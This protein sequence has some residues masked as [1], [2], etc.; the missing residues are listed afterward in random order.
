MELPTSAAVIER[1]HLLAKGMPALPIFTDRAGCVI[2]DVEDVCVDSLT[3]VESLCH[4]G[5]ST[6]GPVLSPHL[7]AAL[8]KIKVLPQ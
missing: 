6:H 7:E 8:T 1:V 2:G 4:D 5:V 3:G